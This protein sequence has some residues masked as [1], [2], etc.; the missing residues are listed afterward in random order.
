MKKRIR[1]PIRSARIANQGTSK[2]KKLRNIREKKKQGLP[3]LLSISVPTIS[4]NGTFKEKEQKSNISKTREKTERKGRKS[5]NFKLL[6]RPLGEKLKNENFENLPIL[7]KR[8]Y[9]N[10]CR[11]SIPHNT[12]YSGFLDL[13]VNRVFNEKNKKILEKIEEDRKFEK[14]RKD[15][16]S[17]LSKQLEFGGKKLKKIKNAKYTK[18]SLFLDPIG[19]V[20]TMIENDSKKKKDKRDIKNAITK[21][22]LRSSRI[23]EKSERNLKEDEKTQKSQL[24]SKRR[25]TIK[26]RNSSTFSQTLFDIYLDQK[27]V[28][29]MKKTR[30]QE[31]HFKRIMQK[32]RDHRMRKLMKSPSRKRIKDIVKKEK[33]I[34]DGKKINYIKVN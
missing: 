7:K 25:S 15:L 3:K 10:L 16:I 26:K 20:E 14:R 23:E 24:K 18:A 2:S 6:K 22:N 33:T 11:L 1:N 29:G 19:Y 9:K 13:S 12:I 4:T 17:K 27:I 31:K 8:R 32:Q 21:S 30:A 5:S 34:D 28:K